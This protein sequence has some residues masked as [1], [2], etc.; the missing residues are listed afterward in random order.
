[1]NSQ[2]HCRLAKRGISLAATLSALTIGLSCPAQTGR[3]YT[4]EDY[5]R[6]A[7]LL[8]AS[9]VSLVDHAVEGASFFSND[10]F[11]YLD[12]DHGLSTLMIADAATQTKSPAY[13]PA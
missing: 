12:S 1:M 5:T 11:W 6:S 13:D 8:T 9:T 3:V 2:H 10:R 4:E 7:N